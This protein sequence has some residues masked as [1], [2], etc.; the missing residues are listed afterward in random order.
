M[1]QQQ[2]QKKMK[3]KMKLKIKMKMKKYNKK[4]IKKNLLFQSTKYINKEKLISELKKQNK[5]L[6]FR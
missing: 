4:K 1:K 3:L 5:F 2:K 6:K